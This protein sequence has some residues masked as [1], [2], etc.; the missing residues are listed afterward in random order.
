MG[1]KVS[2]AALSYEDVPKPKEF[3]G[4]S[5][6]DKRQGEI[7]TWKEFQLGE[8]VREF[9]E[10]ML[11]VSDVTEKEALFAFQNG[12]LPWVRQEV[13]QRGVQKLPEAMTVRNPWSSLV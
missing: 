9:K 7:G 12:L 11:L 2:S 3:V 4:T 5:T 6:T 10:L 13:E 8:H 1:K